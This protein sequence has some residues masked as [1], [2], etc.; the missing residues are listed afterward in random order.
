MS[1][2]DF[3]AVVAASTLWMQAWMDQDRATLDAF[4]GPDFALIVSTVPT[5]PFERSDWLE[6]AVTAYVC[7]RF[8]YEGVHCRRISGD[9]V[10]MSAIADFDATI[11][12]VDRSGR[13]FVTDLWR[14]AGRSAHGWQICARYSSRPGE[15]DASARALLER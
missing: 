1:D 8:T 4:L 10:A 9:L 12:G 14:R 3:D 15:L 11:G 7:T 5:K 13:Y 6:T 2:A